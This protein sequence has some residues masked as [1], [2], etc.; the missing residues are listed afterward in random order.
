MRD[1]SVRV[2]SAN[3]LKRNRKRLKYWIPPAGGK[4]GIAVKNAES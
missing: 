3:G 1:I 2:L 4:V